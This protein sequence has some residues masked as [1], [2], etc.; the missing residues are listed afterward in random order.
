MVRLII[1][2]LWTGLI[3]ISGDWAAGVWTGTGIP[4]QDQSCATIT[5]FS[6]CQ[7]FVQASGSAFNEACKISS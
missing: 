2:I 1:Y 3:L 6:T 7:Q 4:G 5:G